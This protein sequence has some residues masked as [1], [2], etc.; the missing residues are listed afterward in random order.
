MEGLWEDTLA[1]PHFRGLSARNEPL[2]SWFFT[3]F[4]YQMRGFT[5]THLLTWRHH[6]PLEISRL[7]DLLCLLSDRSDISFFFPPIGG[8]TWYNVLRHCFVILGK[9]DYPLG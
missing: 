3:T 8:E 7:E 1:L 4:P 5:F 6:D 9:K 2:F